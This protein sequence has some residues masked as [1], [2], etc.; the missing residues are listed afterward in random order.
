VESPPNKSTITY[1]YGAGERHGP[2]K[3]VWHD[4]KQKPPKELFQGEGIPDNGS[5]IV[6]DKATMYFPGTDF[7]KL[8]PAKAFEDYKPPTPYLPRVKGHHAEWLAACKGGPPTLDGFEYAGRLTEV[9]MLGNIALR[10]GTPIEWDGPNL[11]VTNNPAA[12]QLVSKV[13]RQGWDLLKWVGPIDLLDH[14][15]Q[16]EPTPAIPRHR[17]G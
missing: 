11:R 10:V 4:G 14:S 9:M 13:Y 1:N 3:L 8:L 7:W 5:I 12:Q 17:D 16:S 15:G 6:G 2:L